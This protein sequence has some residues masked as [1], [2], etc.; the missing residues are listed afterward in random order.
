MSQELKCNKCGLTKP[1]DEF[2]SNSQNKSGYFYTCKM[3]RQDIDHLRYKKSHPNAVRKDSIKKQIIFDGDI[4]RIEIQQNIFVCIDK[5]DYPVVSSY[6]WWLSKNKSGNQY[7][8]AVVNGHNIA[9]HR[10]IMDAPSDKQIDH[11]SGYGLDNRRSNLRFATQQQNACNMRKLAHRKYKG[12]CL[13]TDRYKCWQ[14]RIRVEG[15]LIR[16]GNF[17]TELEAVRAYN[18]A[19]LKYHGEF[20]RLNIIE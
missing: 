4:V 16:L 1:A 13:L 2:Y 19:A 7:A 11:I 6:S 9:M 12:I 15:K 8:G 10:L 20:A 18:E 5:E 17:Y 3:C 14:A